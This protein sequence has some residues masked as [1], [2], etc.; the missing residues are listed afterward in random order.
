[1]TDTLLF[2]PV[3]AFPLFANLV[4]TTLQVFWI[5]VF[6]KRLFSIAPMHHIFE[7]KGWSVSKIV[8]RYWIISSISAITGVLLV[9]IDRNT[10]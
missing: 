7:A 5:R 4:V 8:M 3:I 1:M 10:L 2:L 6:K 9:I